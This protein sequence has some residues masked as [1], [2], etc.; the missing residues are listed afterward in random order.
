MPMRKQQP[1]RPRITALALLMLWLVASAFYYIE[2]LFSPNFYLGYDEGTPHK[3]LKYVACAAFSVYF[4]F[5]ARALG[6]MLFCG[7]M[8]VAAAFIILIQGSLEFSSLSIL[9]VGTMMPFILVPALWP[10]RMLLLGRIV[11]L[12]GGVVGIFSV[13][14]VT[15][16]AA[17]FESA[18]TSTGSIRSVS[19]LFN[20]NNLGL[21]AGLALVLLPYVQLRMLWASVC[22]A[23]LLFALA[24]SGSRTAWVALAVVV[25]YAL[26]TSSDARSRLA[27]VVY[28][29]TPQILLTGITLA[30]IY[31]IYVTFSAAPDIET[32]NRTSDFYTASIRLEN[33][34]SFL[35]NIDE[36][37]FFPDLRSPRL[38]YIHD[39][40]YLVAINSFGLVGIALLISFFITHFSLRTKNNTELVPWRLV[41]MFFMI[42][43]LSGSQLNS[44]PNNQ[45]FF[46][47]MGSLFAYRSPFV[48][49]HGALSGAN[50]A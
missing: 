11:V 14:E 40:F 50:A 24:A 38:E 2:H 27:A 4:C 21:Y 46:L 17:L 47:S 30:S 26:A 6:L 16:L 28:R 19:T 3:V 39:N 43:G 35:D 33:F 8:L 12:C 36:S 20:P 9:V 1:N 7:L 18:W 49:T 10:N 22:G 42:S 34:L 48:R 41:F 5:A 31:I 13:I 25:P 44:F 29:R 37:L 15:V 45:L 32:V 23:L